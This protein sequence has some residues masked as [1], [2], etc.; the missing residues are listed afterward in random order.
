MNQDNILE[1]GEVETEQTAC[2]LDTNAVTTI[3]AHP[4]LTVPTHVTT[5]ELLTPATDPCADGPALQRTVTVPSGPVCQFGG[6]ETDLACDEVP[7]DGV[8]QTSEVVWTLV[9]CQDVPN[10][11]VRV[12]NATFAQCASGGVVIKTGFDVDR[13]AIL[14]DSE[15]A[16]SQVVCNGANGSNG[17]NGTDGQTSLAAVSPEPI[18]TNC[19]NGG[20]RVQAGRDANNNGILE[21]GEVTSTS[22]LCN[23]DVPPID[24]NDFAAPNVRSGTVVV[25]T[26][27]DITALANVQ[28]INGSLLVAGLNQ[29]NVNGLG[30][31][32]RVTGDVLILGNSQ[33]T[34]VNG[35]NGLRDVGREL[36]A[37]DND[38]LVTLDGMT[39]LHSVGSRFAASNNSS[40]TSVGNFAVLT[41]V[42]RI[43]VIH[44]VALTS[45]GFGAVTHAAGSLFVNDND[46]L[47]S[48]NLFPAL[49]D[50]DGTLSVQ[51]NGALPS[52]TL[53]ALT[54]V[55]A[56]LS[57]VN[58]A[59][60][61][62]LSAPQL[63][64]V[65]G[66]FSV[67][68][69]NA[70]TSASLPRLTSISADASLSADALLTSLDLRGLVVA[71]RSLILDGLTALNGGL[72]LGALTAVG[73]SFVLNNTAATS[74]SGI[75]LQSTG[76]DLRITNNTALSTGLATAFAGGVSV[77]GTTTISGN[78][79]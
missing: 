16:N 51:D 25:S 26:G 19:A 33:L 63:A 24:C 75:A 74:L 34:N 58:N 72:N 64:F 11:L 48:G 12:D 59:A 37:S 8:I 67:S 3:G 70:M 14:D 52:V 4:G 6:L 23:A 27:A 53:S 61:G 10:E 42:N 78:G 69:N 43:E 22:F 40:L 49:R 20:V 77:G 46:A 50:I 57:V 44:D 62:T 7:L 65:G 41:N 47:T 29:N 9:V 76:R 73:D 17:T 31:L 54:R 5:P 21:L 56:S 68:S 1:P 79:P 18:G 71:S 28:C 66:L 60:L 2:N 30:A 45:V 36:N 15:V 55:G 39:N 32:N 35:L 13:N 38:S